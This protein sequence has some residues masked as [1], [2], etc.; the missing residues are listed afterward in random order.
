[1]ATLFV[2]RSGVALSRERNAIVLRFEEGEVRRLPMRVID[3][4]VVWGSATIDTGLIVALAERGISMAF[5]AG[6]GAGGNALVHGHGPHAGLLR[7][8]QLRLLDDV[9][10]RTAIA[11]AI[12]SAKLRGQYRFVAKLRRARADRRLVLTHAMNEIEAVLRQTHEA[13]S[14]QTLLGLEGAGASA[15]WRGYSS[16]LAQGLGFA[17]RIRRPP[18]DPVNASLSLGYTC[19]VNEAVAVCISLGVDPAVGAL[20]SSVRRRPSL[21]CDLVEPLR[22]GWDRRVYE[23]FRDSLLRSDQFHVRFG[24]C[25]VGQAGRTVLYS[26]IAKTLKVARRWIRRQL[27]IEIAR[28]TGGNSF[29]NH[30]VI[31]SEDG[32]GQGETGEEFND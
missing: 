10:E 28:S 1:M 23:L 22:T 5:H 8:R 4:V 6:R 29:E 26:E 7:L 27:L 3:R 14:I 31:T 25:Q 15:Y 20:H 32:E 21:A 11:R 24:G 19:L 30:P 12:V 18:P 13:E 17:G 16:V 9:T 2:D